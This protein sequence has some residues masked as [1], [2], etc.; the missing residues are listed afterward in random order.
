MKKTLIPG[1][2]LIFVFATGCDWHRIRGNGNIT[3]EQR[4]ITAFTKVEVG[5]ACELKWRPGAPSL[6]LTTDQNL[7]PRI[8][9]EVTSDT[10]RIK[11]HGPLAPT[12]GIKIVIS[13]QNLTGAQLSGA[14]RFDAAQ[15]SEAE[16]ILDTSGAT[17][18]LLDGKATQL[19]ASLTGA[20]EL[21]AGSLQTDSTEISVTGAGRAEVAVASSL[22]ASIT[23]AGKVTYLG[24]PKSVQKEITGAGKIERR[25]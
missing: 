7:L 15:L 3:T 10:L 5:G 14:V 21:R 23:G 1:L 19:V 17:K 8:E 13:S 18:V 22:K 12:H 11:T 25:P 16:F 4:S 2:L 6:G 24:N 9:T 20:S